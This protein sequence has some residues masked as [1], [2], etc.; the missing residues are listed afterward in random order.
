MQEK[1]KK[2]YT[3]LKEFE[4]FSEDYETFKFFFYQNLDPDK[5]DEAIELLLMVVF[6]LLKSPAERFNDLLQLVSEEKRVNLLSWLN[7]N[8]AKVQ[9]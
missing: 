8:I 3:R 5:K 2:A 7:E 9:R 6:S 4:I 1:I